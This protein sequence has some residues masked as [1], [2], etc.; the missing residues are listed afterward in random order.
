MW[1]VHLC[2]GIFFVIKAASSITSQFYGITTQRR[3][4]TMKRVSIGLFL[5]TQWIS[6]LVLVKDY[7]Q[8]Y[9]DRAVVTTAG[10]SACLI[11]V[12]FGRPC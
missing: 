10:S 2:D 5:F 3:T 11:L 7:C 1:K 9:P 4:E 6:C 12:D 8:L